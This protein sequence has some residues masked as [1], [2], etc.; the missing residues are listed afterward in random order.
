MMNTARKVF[1]T[2]DHLEAV[3]WEISLAASLVEEAK[4]ILDP[5]RPNLSLLKFKSHSMMFTLAL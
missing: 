1:K 3:E 2:V 4:E 5:E